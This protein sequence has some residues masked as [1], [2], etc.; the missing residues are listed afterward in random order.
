MT[1]VL[2][3]GLRNVL[4]QDQVDQKGSLCDTKKLRFDFNCR[5]AVSSEQLRQVEQVVRDQIEQK[6]NVYCKVVPL[7][8][9]LAVTTLRAVFG[10]TYPDPV[11]V[12]SVGK[13]VDELLKDPTN[14]EW[15]KYSVELCGGT[16]MM[17]TSD[18]EA[19]VISEEGAFFGKKMFLK[20][21]SKAKKNKD[22]DTE[23]FVLEIL[24]IFDKYNKS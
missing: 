3:L 13:E 9:A 21:L 7:A 4:P 17:N 1:H 23:K 12:V 6:L 18:A 8:A 24:E 15:L 11:R 22:K 20:Y 19:F 16:H 10:E 5:Q 2:N 14:P